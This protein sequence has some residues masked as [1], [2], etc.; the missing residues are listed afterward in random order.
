MFTV[1]PETGMDLVFIWQM[2]WSLTD[3][4]IS[5]IIREFDV[6]PNGPGPLWL[7]WPYSFSKGEVVCKEVWYSAEPSVLHGV[8]NLE[9]TAIRSHLQG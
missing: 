4:L 7:S 9:R 8:F 2:L 5:R 3:R 1:P 6:L